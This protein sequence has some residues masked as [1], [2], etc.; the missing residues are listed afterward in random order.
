MTIPVIGS[1]HVHGQPLILQT[2]AF[3]R[4]SGGLRDKKL[5]GGKYGL[6]VVNPHKYV[7]SNADSVLHKY[8]A[9][10]RDNSPGKSRLCPHVFQ[11]GQSILFSGETTR[12]KSENRRLATKTFLELSVSNPGKK[13]AKLSIETFGNA[14]T[15]FNPNA[16]QFG[17]Y[18]ELQF[19]ER[20]RQ[21]DIKTLNYYLERNRVAAV[22]SGERNF[23]IFT[24][25]SQA[26]PLRQRS[27]GA[28]CNAVRADN[29]HRFEQFK[30]ASKTVGLSKRHVV[31][32][33]QVVAAIL[34]LCNPE[35]IIDCSRDVDAAVVRNVDTLA[36]VP[37][38]LGVQPS[39]LENALSYKL[40]WSR[41]NSALSSSTQ[42]EHLKR[43]RQNTLSLLSARLNKH[44]NQHLCRDNFE[45]FIG[46]FDLPS[47]QNM[48]GRSNSL[49]QFCINF[50]NER[51]H[52]FIQQCLFEAHVDEYQ[53][54]ECVRL[55][56]NRPGG[57][58]HIMD[59]QACRSHKKT[60]RTMV[61]A[62]AK[63]WGNRSSFK[64]GGG[65]DRSGFP[66]FTICHFNGP[67][68]YSS[69]AFL[70]RNLDAL[71]PDFMALLR[72]MAVGAGIADG[73]EG[74]GSINPFAKAYAGRLL[75]DGKVAIIVCHTT[76]P[77]LAQLPPSLK[78]SARMRMSPHPKTQVHPTSQANSAPPSTHSLIHCERQNWFVFCINPNDP[79]PEPARGMI[80]QGTVQG[81]DVQGGRGRSPAEQIERMRVALG[82]G[83]TDVALGWHKVFLSRAAFHAMRMHEA[84]VEAG[85]YVRP[86]GDP[87]APYLTPS[88]AGV[89]EHTYANMYG[90]QAP[91]LEYDEEYDEA[92]TVRSD[93][94]DGRSRL[95]GDR[96]DSNSNYGTKSYAPSRNMFQ[97]VDEE[98]LMAKGAATWGDHGGQDH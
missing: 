9:E 26:H 75:Q 95:T 1:W 56:Q 49:D 30:V 74:A 93:E 88:A 84:E 45:T 21:C 79:T 89:D 32:A 19:T 48:T 5:N 70:E 18:T 68:A 31:Q 60:D 37:E 53:S 82:L 36:L 64:S 14:H 34:H 69:K 92:K 90:D 71:N 46:L 15:L 72:G 35:F 7:S 57:L 78:K 25:L 39:A 3:V 85:L 27:A 58:T 50:A 65:M 59:G 83:E 96:D 86:G 38:S 22:P 55:F 54:E 42:M 8:S 41:R 11:L 91:P 63:R 81:S 2:V 33:C 4:C 6:I 73:G 28:R 52:H 80:S 40:H 24:I 97:H 12:G 29:A 87:Y 13:G 17:K 47:P 16:S 51:L 67:V 43:P 62:S 23:H 98:G 61:E 20:G 66:T 76:T 94:F 10:Y 77:P 44:I